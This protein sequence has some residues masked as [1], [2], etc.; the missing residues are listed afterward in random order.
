M[1]KTDTEQL[2]GILEEFDKETL[3]SV[4]RDLN[5][6]PDDLKQAIRKKIKDL[7]KTKRGKVSKVGDKNHVSKEAYVAAKP[8]NERV[9]GEPD[10]KPVHFLECGWERQ[11]PVARV[12]VTGYWWGTGFLV[13]R[14][15]FMTNNH[16]IE[17]KTQGRAAEMEFNYQ[18]DH[19]GNMLSTDTWDGDP[20]SFFHTDVGLDYTVMRLKGR[21]SFGLIQPQPYTPYL[22][23]PYAVSPRITIPPLPPGPDPPRMPETVEGFTDLIS[24]VISSILNLTRSPY[25]PSIFL[26]KH[27]GDTYG[28][29]PLKDNILTVDERLNIIQHPATRAKEVA[30]NEN[31]LTHI[32]ANTIHY[33]T[34]TEGGSSGSPVFDNTWDIIALH[35]AAGDVAPGGHP[36]LGPWVDNEGMRIDRIIDDLQAN[37]RGTSEEHIL[38]ELGIP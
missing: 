25:A 16:V 19:E 6:K 21:R 18:E 26:T 13:S 4:L 30:M 11:K 1:P 20:D 38:T 24:S 8:Y 27:A 17:N 9:I 35:H 2:K 3:H 14:S 10:F 22:T 34:D 31:I 23:T 15:L 29:I 37:L 7:P 12:H 32:N 5:I 33:T 36:V 28:Y